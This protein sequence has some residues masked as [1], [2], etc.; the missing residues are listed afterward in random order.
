MVFRGPSEPSTDVVPSVVEPLP[1]QVD[2]NNN[3][4]NSND[5]D[6]MMAG[7]KIK[8]PSLA[9]SQGKNYQNRFISYFFICIALKQSLNGYVSIPRSCGLTCGHY[10][11][12]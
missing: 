11:T 8:H 9:S 5:S 12:L 6:A 7:E 4:M 1:V 2:A 3:T 10:P